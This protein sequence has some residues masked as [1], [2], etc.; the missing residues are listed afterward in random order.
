MIV[1]TG[2]LKRKSNKAHP[3]TINTTITG[4]NYHFGIFAVLG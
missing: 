3:T 1:F 2:T 4:R